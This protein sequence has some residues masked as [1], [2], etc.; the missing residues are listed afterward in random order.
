MGAALLLIGGVLMGLLVG[1]VFHQTGYA[2]GRIEGYEKGMK[3]TAD[4]LRDVNK[5]NE[6]TKTLI[7]EAAKRAKA[8][9]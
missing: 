1:S 3:E 7:Y 6:K 9:E 4:I 8:G 2:K 5:I